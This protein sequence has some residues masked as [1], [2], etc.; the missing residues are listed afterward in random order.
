M[1]G[2]GAGDAV[3]VVAVV[4]GHVGRGV[5]GPMD[6]V[7]ESQVVGVEDGVGATF[8]VAIKDSEGFSLS[9]HCRI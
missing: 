2:G 3:T 9:E 8:V 1:I 7:E 5:G 4:H 6:G